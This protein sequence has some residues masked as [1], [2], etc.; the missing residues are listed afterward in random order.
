[1]KGLGEE[2]GEKKRGE[3]NDLQEQEKDDAPNFSNSTLS[4]DIGKLLNQDDEY[5]NIPC[6]SFPDSRSLFRRIDTPSP[7]ALLADKTLDQNSIGSSGDDTV[8]NFPTC[9]TPRIS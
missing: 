1:M 2:R 8:A 4:G 5:T 7:K 9:E 6:T 3:R